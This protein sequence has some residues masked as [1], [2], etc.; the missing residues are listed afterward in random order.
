MLRLQSGRKSTCG[1]CTSVHEEELEAVWG[2]VGEQGQIIK[3][4]AHDYLD[5]YQTL[6]KKFW[7]QSNDDTGKNI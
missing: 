6:S 7:R 1:S 5:S 3:M 4:I 2:Y